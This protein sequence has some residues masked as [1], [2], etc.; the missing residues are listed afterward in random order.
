[1]ASAIPPPANINLL[2]AHRERLRQVEDDNLR[3]QLE[4]YRTINSDRGPVRGHGGGGTS[5]GT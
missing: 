2:F 3:L 1:M 4:D 5:Q